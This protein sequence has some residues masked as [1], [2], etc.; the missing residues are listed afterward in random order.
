MIGWFTDQYFC[1]NSIWLR[2]SDHV[3]LQEFVQFVTGSSS[4]PPGGLSNLHPRLCVV[5]KSTT[6]EGILPSVNT[7]FH[8]LKLPEYKTEEEL[9]RSLMAATKE[10]EFHL[11]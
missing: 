2:V 10:K 9:Y 4:L 5:R 8:Y 11:N 1:K 6:Y 7:C 3:C